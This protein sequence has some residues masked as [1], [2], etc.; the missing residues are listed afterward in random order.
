M[1][2]PIEF[3]VLTKTGGPLTK[4]ISLGPSDKITSDGNACYMLQLFKCVI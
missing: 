4:R 2:E 1:S 3:A